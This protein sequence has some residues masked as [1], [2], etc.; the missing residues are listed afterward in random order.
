MQ[1]PRQTPPKTK[2]NKKNVPQEGESRLGSVYDKIIKENLEISLKTIIQD[3]S[4]LRIV[5]SEPLRTRMQHTK[6]RDPDELSLIWLPDGTQRILH[7][8][9]HLKD[10]Y[11]I[12][13]RLCDYHIMFKRKKKVPKM[14][15]YVIYIGSD[16]PKYLTGTWE[17]ESLVFH[18]NV[19]ILKKIPYQVF[20]DA[21]NPE[22]VVF[23]ILA[24]FQGEDAETIGKK[25]ATRLQKLSKTDSEKEKFYT[26]LRV[27]S[28]VRKL[29]PIIDKIMEN[30]FKLID[31]SEDPLYVEG[32]LEGIDEGIVIG[33]IQGMLEKEISNVKSFIINSDFND[34]RIALILSTDVDVV[35]KIRDDLFENKLIDKFKKELGKSQSS[36]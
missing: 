14:V 28:N 18:Y 1:K 24:D 17:T 22:S 32:K 36:L 8:E 12:N 25:I 2:R 15:Q 3:V 33:K 9:A 30:I 35:E 16:D 11:A 21:E 23:S 26:Q 19:I 29:Q 5:K 6:E 10:E 13:C 27:L 4:G 20:L 7:A 31:I 34:E